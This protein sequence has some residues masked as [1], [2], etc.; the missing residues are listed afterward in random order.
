MD[1]SGLDERLVGHWRAA[2]GDLGIRI[3]APVELKDAAGSPFACEALVHDFGSPRGALVASA[4][5]E[6]RVRQALRSLGDGLWVARVGRDRA[7]AYDR[8]RV[9]DELL[10]WGWCARA[11]EEPGWYS[12]LVPRSG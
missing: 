8:K 10:D 6:R 3:T 12:Q 2:A 9:V 1:A 11:G 7:A 4:K 5:T